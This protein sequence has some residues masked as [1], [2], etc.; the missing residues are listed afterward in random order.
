ME[1]YKTLVMEWACLA[2]VVRLAFVALACRVPLRSQAGGAVRTQPGAHCRPELEGR[3]IAT[4]IPGRCP[5]RA[6][7]YPSSP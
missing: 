6:G 7:R 5:V 1:G 4:I 3:A 2:V